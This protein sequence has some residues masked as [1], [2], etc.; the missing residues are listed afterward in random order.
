MS[1]LPL[2]RGN[3]LLVDDEA[4]MGDYLVEGLSGAGFKAT[5]VRSGEEALAQIG[6]QEFDA[7]VTDLRMKGMD[8]LELCRRVREATAE[9][10]VVVLTAFGDYAAAVEA[11]RAGAY[12]F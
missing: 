8:G 9:L 2:N 7:L 6:R 5:A 4:A 10:P 11:V 12:D 1:G 3:V